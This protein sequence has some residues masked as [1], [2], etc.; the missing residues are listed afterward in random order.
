[1]TQIEEDE[2]IVMR[3]GKQVVD[4]EPREQIDGISVAFI[5]VALLALFSLLFLS[6]CDVAS[7]DTN[8]TAFAKNLPFTPDDVVAGIYIV[9]GGKRASRP[10]GVMLEGCSWDNEDYCRL[11]CYNTVINNY[12]RF[13]AS[14]ESDYL[15]FL[16]RRY[17]PLHVSNDPAGLNSNWLRNIKS[18]LR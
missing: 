8:A 16:A 2:G 13:L 15:A 10:Y 11:I 6:R 3:F 1:M 12:K 17:A 14:G 5:I 18:I 7:A 4:Q 9:E